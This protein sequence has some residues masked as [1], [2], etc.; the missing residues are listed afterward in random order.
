VEIVIIIKNL[1]AL[2]YFLHFSFYP[3]NSM[4]HYSAKYN[5]GVKKTGLI[6]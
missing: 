6:F 1:N 5:E 2:V 4:T 3:R